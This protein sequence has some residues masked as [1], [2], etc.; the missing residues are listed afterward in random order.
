M[1]FPV[2]NLWVCIQKVY[3]YRKRRIS[4]SFS[5]VYILYFYRMAASR[6]SRYVLNNERKS[7]YTVI[8]YLIKLPYHRYVVHIVP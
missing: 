3:L 7:M 6:K 4:Y 8:S 2:L 5:T 1:F